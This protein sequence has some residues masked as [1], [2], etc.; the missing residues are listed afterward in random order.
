MS[1]GFSVTV[2]R[3]HSVAVDDGSFAVLVSPPLSRTALT[4]KSLPAVSGSHLHA[5]VASRSVPKATIRVTTA[6]G[7]Y[8]VA[9]TL[10]YE[11]EVTEPSPFAVITAPTKR[12]ETRRYQLTV[13][14]KQVSGN[15]ANNPVSVGDP[16]IRPGQLPQFIIFLKSNPESIPRS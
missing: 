12:T 16:V 5:L 14:D 2:S 4:W 10:S 1:M 3:M 9:R 11:V 15:P 8:A 6:T 13:D 7:P